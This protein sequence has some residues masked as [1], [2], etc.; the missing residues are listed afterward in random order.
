MWKK[1]DFCNV[2]IPSEDTKILDFNK[3]QTFDEIPFII[4]GGLKFIIEKVDRY[5]NKAENWSTAKASKHI[6]SGFLMSTI[7]SLR[8]IE[9][10]HDVC[11]GKFHK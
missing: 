6:P 10:K 7:S 11:K 3:Y 1:K 4:Y 5:K 8:S 2:I 9:K